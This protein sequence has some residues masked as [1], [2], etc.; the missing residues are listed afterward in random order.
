LIDAQETALAVKMAHGAFHFARRVVSLCVIADN[1]TSRGLLE[2]LNARQ[3]LAKRDN[4]DIRIVQVV[5]SKGLLFSKDDLAAAGDADDEVYLN[6]DGYRLHEALERMGGP[7]ADSAAHISAKSTYEMIETKILPQLQRLPMPVLVDCSRFAA[8]INGASGAMMIASCYLACLENEVR[9]CVSNSATMNAFGRA[10]Q[11]SG[12]S[13]NSLPCN[14]E[15]CVTDRSPIAMLRRRRGFL[16]YDSAATAGLPLLQTI[17]DQIEAGRRVSIVQGSMSATLGLILDRIGRCGRS[18][19][20]AVAEACDLGIAEPQVVTDLTGHDIAD[21]FR[22]IA[23]ALGWDLPDRDVKFDPLVPTACLPCGDATREQILDAVEAFDEREAFAKRAAVAYQ[24][25]RRWR[26]ISTLKLHRRGTATAHG[27]LEEVDEE[28]FAFSIR[29]Q[30][31]VC[32]LREDVQQ[33]CTP[34]EA[35]PLL[36]LRGQGAG[37]AAGEGTLADVVRLT[38]L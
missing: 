38:G 32:A 28:H 14:V 36:V 16:R 26:Y 15:P 21:K 11:M 17:R 10:M 1:E 8:A 27:T 33:M 20:Q 34:A 37:K 12:P 35:N 3:A 31:I 4:L 2:K 6:P 13:R 29:G 24:S 30:E 18:L 5:T 7:G 19:R 9:V 22:V 25:G 23:F